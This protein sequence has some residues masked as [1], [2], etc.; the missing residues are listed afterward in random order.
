MMRKYETGKT[1]VGLVLNYDDSV[2]DA[3]KGELIGTVNETMQP[4]HVSL[5]LRPGPVSKGGDGASSEPPG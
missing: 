3:L 2:L 5:W 1:M 4:T